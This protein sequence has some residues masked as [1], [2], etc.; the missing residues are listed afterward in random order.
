VLSAAGTSSFKAS[1]RVDPISHLAAYDLPGPGEY[2]N[3]SVLQS[4]GTKNS[5]IG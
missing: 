2:L 3:D 5:P 4:I 1:G